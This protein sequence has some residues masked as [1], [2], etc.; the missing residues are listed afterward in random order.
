MRKLHAR[1]SDASCVHDLI[2]L[3]VIGN[4]G[5]QGTNDRR[6][7][8]SRRHFRE[9]FADFNS[10]NTRLYL[11]ERAASWTPRLGVPSLQLACSTCEPQEDNTLVCLLELFRKR[12]LAEQ[13]YLSHVGG[14]TRCTDCG[15]AKQLASIKANA[16]VNF[17]DDSPVSGN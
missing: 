6:F 1:F 4:L 14:Q 8:Q 13:L 12:W 10:R 17:H 11:G 5:V 15:R 9:Q 2:R 7:M 16:W 3:T